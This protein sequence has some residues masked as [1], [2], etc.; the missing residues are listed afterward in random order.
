MSELFHDMLA[1]VLEKEAGLTRSRARSVA[2]HFADIE[3]FLAAEHWSFA[4]IRSVTGRRAIRLTEDQITNIVGLQG[5]GHLSPQ[6]SV[7][8]NFLSA[9]CRDFTK[10]QLSM[11]RSLE[12]DDLIPNPFLIRSLNLRT[13]EEVVHINVYMRATR[14]IVTSMG[15]FVERLLRASSE[16]IEEAPGRSG[17]DL[18]KTRANG[19]NWLQVKSG[20]NDMDKDQIVYWAE[21]IEEKLSEGDKAYIGIT[22]GKRASNTVTIGLMKQHLPDWEMKTLIG[23]ELWG[24]VSDDPNHHA[25]VLEVLRHAAHQVL[26]THSISEELDACVD[27]MIDEFTR[28]YGEGS[29][30][31]STYIEALF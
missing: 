22:Y 14:S 29:L 31:V 18:V 4:N 10:R 28:R 6:L 26:G 8:E 17:W 24:F 15:F 16:T 20:P 11:I 5:L 25:K 12:L 19:E 27:R 30:G 3:E 1:F 2:A 21:K 9:I 23:R 13:P 7:A